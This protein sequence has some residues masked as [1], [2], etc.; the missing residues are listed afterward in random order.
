M[1]N[2]RQ[3]G[4]DGKSFISSCLKR[5]SVFVLGLI[6]YGL[7]C[8][9]A[10]ILKLTGQ[11]GAVMGTFTTTLLIY[12]FIASLLLVVVMFYAYFLEC[13]S[14][15]PKLKEKPLVIFGF[16]RLGYYVLMT[17]YVCYR[18]LYCLTNTDKV[19][20][21]LAFFYIVYFIFILLAVFANT[22][23]LN[24]LTRNII[25]RSYV[26]SFHILSALG[27]IIQII[28]PIAYIVARVTMG[29][30]GDEYF[31]ASFCDLFRLCLCPLLYVCIWFIYFNSVN[32]VNMV[33]SEVDSA[34]RDKRYQITY[35][36][37]E[38]D[39][40][41]KKHSKKRRR[42]A[43]KAD[44]PAELPAPVAAEP[45][46]LTEPEQTP[47]L[48]PADVP[49]ANELPEP[50]IPS[51]QKEPIPAAPTSEVLPKRPAPVP[52]QIKEDFHVSAPAQVPAPPVIMSSQIQPGSAPLVE[53]F[54]PFPRPPK[55]ARPQQRPAPAKQRQPQRG[56]RPA[57][58]PAGGAGKKG[59]QQPTKYY[60]PRDSQGGNSHR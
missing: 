25:R 60:P 58:R 3:I 19:P 10:D 6:L 42:K 14:N 43:K 18:A 20:G 27:I 17:Y 52:P 28:L 12:D 29:S 13:G 39:K 40:S 47:A 33:F 34:L 45:P 57:Q 51:A 9:V 50:A 11:S 54:N 55:Q 23:A 38:D 37:D 31:T 26:K 41:K 53:D 49:A 5:N 7:L 15:I 1:K 24:I 22:F 59:G 48:P 56:G 16:F 21:T 30:T 32:S 44:A 46:A 8:S 4:L 36:T 2:N 35:S